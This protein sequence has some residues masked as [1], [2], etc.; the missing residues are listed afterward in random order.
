MQTLLINSM[1]GTVQDSMKDTEMKKKQSPFFFKN[2][3]E[4]DKVS[5]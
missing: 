2:T 5:T 4:K 3:N 1:Q